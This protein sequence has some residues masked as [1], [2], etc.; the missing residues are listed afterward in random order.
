VTAEFEPP[1]APAIIT[2]DEG[3]QMLTNVVGIAPADLAI[4]MRVQVQ[5]RNV[6]TDL[7]FPTSP[8]RVGGGESVAHQQRAACY[9]LPRPGVLAANDEQLTAGEIKTRAELSVGHFYWSPSVSHVRRELNRLL[10]RGMVGEIGAQSGKRAIT[11]YETTDAGSMRFAAGCNTFRPGSGRHQAPG[12]PQ[13]LA[14]S[15]RGSRNVIDTLERHL[16]ASSGPPWTRRCGRGSVPASSASPMIRAAFL[17]RRPR[18]RDPRPVR[19]D[20]QH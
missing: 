15:R 18:L 10:A 12:H 9:R 14:G 4:G 1:Y 5:F 6:G 3:Y 16:E 17:L 20:L 2:L 7:R 13:N 11:L 8:G 19:R